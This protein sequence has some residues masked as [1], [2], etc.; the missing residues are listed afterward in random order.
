[1][2]KAYCL[3]LLSAKFYSLIKK[4]SEAELHKETLSLGGCVACILLCLPVY[5]MH[6]VLLETRRGHQIPKTEVTDLLHTLLVLGGDPMLVQ[7][8]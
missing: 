4:K 8:S 1:M 5:H 2:Q 7:C 6:A 3:C